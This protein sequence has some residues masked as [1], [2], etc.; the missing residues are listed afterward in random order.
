MNL[1]TLLSLQIKSQE[2]VQKKVKDYSR[3]GAC[4]L[5]GV[6]RFSYADYADI[7]KYQKYDST[8][9]ESLPT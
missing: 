4:K 8:V 2:S 6:Q 9:K 1:N 5:K 3:D 7:F